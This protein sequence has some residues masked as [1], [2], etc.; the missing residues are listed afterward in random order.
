M[1]G[2]DPSVRNNATINDV[3]REIEADIDASWDLAE[4]TSDPRSLRLTE[5]YRP[6]KM[7]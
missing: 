2:L 3:G 1:E 4:Y 7:P 6:L 5:G